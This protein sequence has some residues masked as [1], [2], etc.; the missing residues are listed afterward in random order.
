[1]R[2]R[3][4]GSA[5]YVIRP[6]ASLEELTRVFD[7]LGA[8]A[9]PKIAHEDRRFTELARRFPED[10]SLMLVMESPDGR[11]V[12]GLLGC[13]RGSGVAPRA[14]AIEP[15]LPRDELMRRLLQTLEI[16]ARRLG[17]DEIFEGGVGDDSS[18]YERQGYFGRNPMAK[19]LLPLPGRAREALLRKLASS[20]EGQGG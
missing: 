18:L 8:Q 5:G 16:E 12:G 2:R 13:R 4:G 1:V 15:G 7:L 17:A 3:A 10:R 11:I 14:I 6:V 9:T 20:G 19:R